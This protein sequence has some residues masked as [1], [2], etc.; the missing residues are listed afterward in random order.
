MM[1]NSAHRVTLSNAPDHYL[2]SLEEASFRRLEAGNAGQQ[3]R[4][5]AQLGAIQEERRRREAQNEARRRLRWVG[6]VAAA[7]AALGA[8]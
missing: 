3:T 1:S 8:R 7:Q 4:A 2:S 5:L 6:T